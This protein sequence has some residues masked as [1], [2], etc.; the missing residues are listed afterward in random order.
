MKEVEGAGAGAGKWEEDRGV[1][2]LFSQPRGSIDI[3]SVGHG[4][5]TRL[6]KTDNI[7]VSNEEER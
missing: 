5:S 6:S 7:N 3:C 1:V 2:V 4:H